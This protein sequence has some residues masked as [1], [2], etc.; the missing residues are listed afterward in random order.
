MN[1]TKKQSKT[2]G[3]GGGGKC[4]VYYSEKFKRLVVEKTVG[5]KFL[6]T[7]IENR[8]RL[9]TLITNNAIDEILL[10]KEMIFMLLTKIAKLDCCV[11]ILDYASNPFRIIMEYC[12]GGDIR[13]ILDRYEV[14]ASDKMI[15]ISQILMAVKR[16]HENGFIHGDLKCANIFLVNKYIPG[17]FKNIKIKIGDFGLSEIGG[18]LVFGGTPGF[19]APEVPFI[20]GSFDS[21]IYSVG[22]VMLEIM[23]QL[24]IQMIQVINSS[25]IY[26]LK[27]KLPKFM[28]ITQFYDIVIS[29]LNKEYKERPS[30]DEVYKLFHVLLTLWLFGEDTNNLILQKYRLGESVPVDTHSHPLILS[31]DEMRQNHSDGWYCSICKNQKDYF[32]NNMFSFHCKI[33][34]YNLCY[35]CMKIHDYRVVND[36]M[37][38]HAPKGK[39][40]YVKTHPHYLLLSGKEDRY[41]GKDYNWFCDI[42]KIVTCDSLYS[43]H[44]KKCEYDVCLKCFEEYFEIRKEKNCCCC[45]I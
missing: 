1:I 20:G 23:T 14:P 15:M 45:F 5:D 9:K 2:L 27:K 30:A 29:C 6:K 21:D 39:K 40:V 25:N 16:I 35:T 17:D 19:M 33:C 37:I 31:N 8:T 36:K 18:D 3:I 7:K 28:D 32:F 10:G 24:P 4:V 41:N 13:N 12:E 34:D 42:C 43:F 26:S 38:E 22:K 44:C 11:E